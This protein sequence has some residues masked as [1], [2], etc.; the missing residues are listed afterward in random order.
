[1]QGNLTRRRAASGFTLIEL[2][3]VVAALGILA[4]IA[5]PKMTN[6]IN[7]AKAARTIAIV[8]PSMSRAYTCAR[9]VQVF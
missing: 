9:R 3:V 2:M 8:R 4:A 5:V 7:K 1:M 6:Q